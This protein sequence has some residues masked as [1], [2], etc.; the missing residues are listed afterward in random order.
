MGKIRETTPYEI[1]SKTHRSRSSDRSYVQHVV[2]NRVYPYHLML[3][4]DGPISSIPKMSYKYGILSLIVLDLMC[5]MSGLFQPYD[6][7]GVIG[8]YIR[9][10][11]EVVQLFPTSIDENNGNITFVFDL[12][13]GF[14]F[15]FTIVCSAIY[16]YFNFKASSVCIYYMICK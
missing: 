1:L 12:V 2:A 4:N 3:V 5:I 15:I 13:V 6:D 11:I 8:S 7:V 10:L 14:M 16:G 9:E